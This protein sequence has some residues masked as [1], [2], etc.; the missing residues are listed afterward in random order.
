MNISPNMLGRIQ[1]LCKQ[2]ELTINKKNG[3][4]SL[5]L[6]TGPVPEAYFNE[7]DIDLFHALKTITMSCQL[8]MHSIAR[9]NKK[10]DAY[11][12]GG[13]VFDKE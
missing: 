7:E 3:L 2:G 8:M 12:V 6:Y 11:S 9:A 13:V 5:H 1:W 4:W 10:G